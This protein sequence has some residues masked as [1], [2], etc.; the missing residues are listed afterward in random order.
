MT[1]PKATQQQELLEAIDRFSDLLETFGDS[2]REKLAHIEEHLA[3]LDGSVQKIQ[4]SLYGNGEPGV[5][6]MLRDLTRRVEEIEQ[7]EDDCP[8]VDVAADV[9]EIKKIHEEQKE[10]RQKEEASREK[11]RSDTRK[12][13]YGMITLIITVLGDI[14]LRL[15]GK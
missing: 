11:A 8:I 13:L 1:P 9:D 7:A 10:A 12:F 3:T 14:A 2:T 15:L 5:N 6:E 4:K